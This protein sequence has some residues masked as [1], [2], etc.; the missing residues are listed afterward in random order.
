MWKSENSDGKCILILD[1][2]AS[3]KIFF[4]NHIE[5]LKNI[6][7]STGK[8]K[9]RSISGHFTVE[10]WLYRSGHFPDKQY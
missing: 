4:P 6:T 7:E 9:S 8:K 10:S 2:M 3:E 5:S 1:I